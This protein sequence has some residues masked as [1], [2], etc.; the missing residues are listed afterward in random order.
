MIAG[1]LALTACGQTA[2]AVTNASQ[3]VATYTSKL[4]TNYTNALPAR[5]QLVI[6][7]LKLDGTPNAVTTE[8]AAAL[9]PLWQAAQS[10][11]TNSNTA[12]AEIDAVYQQIEETMTPA[13]IQAIAAM[14]LTQA[15]MSSL[16]QQLGF[17]FAFNPQR[18]MSADQQATAVVARATRQA[19]RQLLGGTGGQGIPGGFPDGGAGRGFA[20]GQPGEFANRGQNGTTGSSGTTN[21]TTI[22]RTRFGGGIDEAVIRY[23][24]GLLGTPTPTMPAFP[25]QRNGT[26]VPPPAVGTPAP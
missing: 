1:M 2:K 16:G 15:D 4:P 24:E 14:K 9:L 25:F 6:G 22:N 7:T 12:K 3:P 8:Q 19:E 20:G 18:T 21:G 13:Q 26:P 10:L 11:S 23:L 17:N 5:T